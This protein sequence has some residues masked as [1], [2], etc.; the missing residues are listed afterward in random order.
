MNHMSAAQR[1]FLILTAGA[2]GMA[3]LLA[4]LPAAGQDQMW[5]DRLQHAYM[6]EDLNR[7]HPA[8]LLVERCEDPA[9]HCQILEGRH[10]NLRAFFLRDPAFAAI[11]AHY[12]YQRSA[13]AYDAYVRAGN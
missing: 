12:R 6:V 10:D 11:F 5:C 3:V 9:V 8:L 13:G 7:W 4:L 1:T 2:V